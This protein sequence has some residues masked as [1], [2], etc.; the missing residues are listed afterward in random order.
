M[1]TVSENDI[2][3]RKI[4]NRWASDETEPVLLVEIFVKKIYY[5]WTKFRNKIKRNYSWTA[6]SKGVIFEK[7]WEIWSPK[8]KQAPYLMSE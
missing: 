6:P 2:S 7:Y 4:K 1:N 8:H 3:E 5:V